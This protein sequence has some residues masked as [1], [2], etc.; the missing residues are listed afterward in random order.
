MAIH[1]KDSV[2]SVED[3]AATTLRDLSTNLTNV[4]FARSN[5]VHD[6]TGF[7]SDGHTFIAGL[8][9]GTI[10]LTGWTD[11]TASTGTLTVLDSLLGL[12]STTV[13]W[14]YGPHGSGS[15]AVKYSG[16]CV[17][18]SLDVSDPVADLVSFTCQ[19]QISG[20]VT[21]GTYSA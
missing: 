6:K 17:L 20:D 1:G 19:L 12:G 14:E 18:A 5:D 15:G 7:G 11:T 2:F 8:T 13:G 21:V 10:T 3:S 9:N 4:A 16:E